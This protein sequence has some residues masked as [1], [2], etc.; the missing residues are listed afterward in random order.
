MQIYSIRHDWPEKAGFLISR[1]QGHRLYTFLHFQ[2]PIQIMTG[3]SVI[4]A[5]PGACIF[6]KPGTPQWFH[7]ET[8]IVHN[9][10]HF[11]GDLSSKLEAYQIPQD[12][13]LYP[14]DCSFISDL[15]RLLELEHFSENLHKEALMEHLTEEFLLRFARGLSGTQVAPPS[16]YRE[17]AQLRNIRQQILSSPETKWTVAQM[18]EQLHLSVSRFHAVYKGHFGTSPMHDLIDARIARAKTLLLTGR[19]LDMVQLAE[20]LGYN[21]QYHFIRQFKSHTGQTPGAYR[22]NLNKY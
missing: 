17:K 6:Y 9:W 8:D 11:T 20:Q 22:R 18:A 12:T 15:F 7:S 19:E 4:T 10:A 3:R 14:R 13:L 5:R 16:N 1:P 2:Q 21:D